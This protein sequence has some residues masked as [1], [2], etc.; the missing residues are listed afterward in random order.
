MTSP[1]PGGPGARPEHIAVGLVLG[2]VGVNGQ[3]KVR[4]LTDFPERLLELTRVR[5]KRPGPLVSKPEWREVAAAEERGD[6]G[7][8]LRL[9]GVTSREQAAALRGSELE[10]EA[11]EARPLPP[12]RFYRFQVIGLTVK[13]EAGRTLGKVRDVLE[14]GA[15]DVFVVV[16]EGGGPPRA[17]ILIP[18]LRDVI[19]ALDLEAGEMVVRPLRPWG[20]GS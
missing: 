12:D 19:V 2:A 20:D 18:A 10:I 6:G 3:V 11:S 17:E 1:G 16:P 15:N 14:T 13:D 7:L 9:E 5:V 4:P 8:V